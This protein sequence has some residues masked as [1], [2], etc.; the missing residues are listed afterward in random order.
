MIVFVILYVWQNI[1]IVKMEIIY[2]NL[3]SRERQLVKDNDRLL[4]EIERYRRMDV[5]EEY[6]RKKGLR[7]IL[8]KDFEVLVIDTTNAQ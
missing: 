4:Y 1:E 8:P 2:R 5:M 6:A 3:K 7:K